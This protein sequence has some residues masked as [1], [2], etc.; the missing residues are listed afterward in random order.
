MNLEITNYNFG[1][2]PTVTRPN[3]EFLNVLGEAGIRDMVSRFYD[4]VRQSS[5]KHLFKEDEFEFEKSKEHSADFMI[6]ILGGPEYY[7]IHRGKPKMTNRHSPFSITPEGRI[8]WLSCYREILLQ[9]DAPEHLIVSFWNY[10][11]VFSN[12]MVN[13][14]PT[15]KIFKI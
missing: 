8:V 7:N 2:K 11:N 12:W 15:V 6:Q 14:D 13:T 3:P 5:I 1:E 4:L 9:I 10:L